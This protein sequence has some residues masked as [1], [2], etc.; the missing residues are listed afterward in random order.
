[1]L[2]CSRSLQCRKHLNF[3]SSKICATL[4]NKPVYTRILDT[5]NAQFSAHNTSRASFYSSISVNYEPNT[6]KSRYESNALPAHARAVICGGG[7]MGAA[8]AYHLA[9]KGMGKQVVLLEQERFQ[10]NQPIHS[11]YI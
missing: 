10:V 3:A 8:V 5:K 7:V 4:P 11:T 1:M 2:N 6:E 9:I